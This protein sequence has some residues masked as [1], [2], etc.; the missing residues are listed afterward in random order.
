MNDF[1]ALSRMIENLIRLGTIAAVDHAAQRVR[2]LTGDLLTGWLPWASPRA[3]AD[4]EWNAPTLNEQVLLFSPSG[5]TANGVVLTGLFSDLIPPNG[6]RDAL[7]RTTYRDGAVIEY[8]SAAH[9]LRAVLPAA[10][11]TELISDGGIR[12]VGDITHQGD[13]IQTG[14]QT[15]TGKVTV[16]DDVIAKG[17]SL[18]GHTHGGV[19]PGGATTG[20]PQ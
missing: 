3:G 16:S 1:A 13:Y 18:V 14:N 15:V 17:I 2:V 8:D 11:T 12:I 9:H 20:K 19:I 10:G 6:D 7:H 4:R 5:Q